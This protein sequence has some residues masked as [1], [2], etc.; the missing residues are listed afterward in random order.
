M[1][2]E[3]NFITRF[4]FSKDRPLFS[5]PDYDKPYGYPLPPIKAFGNVTYIQ[6]MDILRN[7]WQK[8]HPEVQFA[9]YGTRTKFNPQ[10]GYIIYSVENKKTT[11]MN[12]KPRHREDLVKTD[13]CD[14]VAT[15]Y[16]QSFD[17][18]IR[19][20]AI[21]ED[22][23]VA[24]QLLEAFEDFMIIIMPEMK[25]IGVEKLFYNR[26]VSDRDLSKTGQ[27]NACRSVIYM[28]TLQKL[29]IAKPETLE[30][31]RIDVRVNWSQATPQTNEVLYADIPYPW[32]AV[33]DDDGNPLKDEYGH[34]ILIDP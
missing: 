3:D 29:L 5:D 32:N 18:L 23:H 2:A 19:F 4:D 26:R 12:S 20:D 25:Y 1:M 6:L 8:M 17:Y 22:P 10:K 9:P 34:Y 11:E 14:Y 30:A 13:T 31:I 15:V 27:D 28:A 33:L 7:L 21:H 16:T 24:E